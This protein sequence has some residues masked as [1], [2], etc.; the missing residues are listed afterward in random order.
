MLRI[1]SFILLTTLFSCSKT[2]TLNMQEHVSGRTPKRIVWLQVAGLSAEHLALLRFSYLDG[3]S[4]TSFEKMNCTGLTWAYNLFEIRPRAEVSAWSQMLGTRNVKDQCADFAHMPLWKFLASADYRVGVLENITSETSSLT[5]ALSCAETP[6]DFLSDLTL[7]KM[8]P[9]VIPKKMTADIEA[10]SPIKTFH[11]LKKQEYQKGQIYFDQACHGRGC[12]SAFIDNV[13]N[14]FEFVNKSSAYL[15]LLRDFSYL[16]TLKKKEAL[17]TREALS[18]LNK[19]LQYFLNL[20]KE[21]SDMLVVV[22]S[23]GP[24]NLELPVQGKSWEEFEKTGHYVLF[25]S[26]SLLAPV[27]AYGARAENF[28]G[29][30]EEAEV[31]MRMMIDP[32]QSDKEKDYLKV[33]KP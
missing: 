18:E 20:A 28:C 31:L 13:T 27:F 22:T 32:A 25:H 14:T 16:E 19:I 9:N 5:R 6:K 8:N 12:Y 7:W 15:Y 33:Y 10:S 2:N 30:Y 26:T 21:D 3:A 1:L 11:A 17:K 29:M 24:L 4:R 23:A